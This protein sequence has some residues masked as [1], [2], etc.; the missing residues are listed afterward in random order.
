MSERREAA[1]ELMRRRGTERARVSLT[2]Q[3]L[4]GD[5]IR[6]TTALKAVSVKVRS[7]EE[8]MR[9]AQSALLG[10]GVSEAAAER[11][12]DAVA[13][14]PN[15]R[16]AA[17]LD[18]QTGGR[19]DPDWERGVRVSAFDWAPGVRGEALAWARS[20]RL[21]SRF[22]DALAL[23]SKAALLP[24]VTAEIG[25][26]DDP[27]YLPGYAASRKGGYI[28]FTQMKRFGDPNGGRA[29]FID[30]A[31]FDAERD[32]AALESDPVLIAG[33]NAD[34]LLEIEHGI[35]YL[36]AVRRR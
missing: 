30:R 2:M 20:L 29:Y 22:L 8:G 23:A 33:L 36:R 28:R 27:A 1:E 9:L 32:I 4:S 12:V 24:C 18:S 10:W 11:A 3:P 31:A 13:R 17:L 5:S 25:L 35:H 21:S 16:G 6:R 7:A 14:G 15:M 34:A 19:L 26:S